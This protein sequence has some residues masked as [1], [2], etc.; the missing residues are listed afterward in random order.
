MAQAR[1][2]EQVVQQLEQGL[3][4]QQAVITALQAGQTQAQA[5][6]QQAQNEL[7]QAQADVVAARQEAAQAQAV[8]QAVQQQAAA[9]PQGPGGQ[10]GGGGRTRIKIMTFANAADE[11]W[12]VWKFHF[13]KARILNGYTDI[14][15][16]LALSAAMKGR[17]AA[18]VMDIEVQRQFEDINALLQHYDRRFLPAS[19]SQMARVSFDQAVQKQGETILDYHSKIRQLWNRAYPN[20]ADEVLLIRKFSLGLRKKE[21]REQVI[22]QNPQTYGA[23]LEAAQNEASVMRVV[24]VTETGAAVEPMEIG[25]VGAIRRAKAASM[26]KKNTGTKQKQISALRTR[27]ATQKTEA[28]GSKGNCHFCS[29]PGHYRSNCFLFQKAKKLMA[30]G[31]GGSAGQNQRSPPWKKNPRNFQRRTGQF[32]SASISMMETLMEEPEAEGIPEDAF[33]SALE[34]LE[35][36]V[37]EEDEDPD[38]VQEDDEAEDADECFQ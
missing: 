16:K 9:A 15:A 32:S 13:D 23:A 21:V 7:Q 37:D 5:S 3:G 6:L 8:A 27:G 19:A 29:K 24:S 2:L 26:Q 10:G 31:R 18:A 30:G 11:D 33:E 22:R 25:M 34:Q 28:P 35:E 36:L 12:L 20:N 38:D 4:Q 17:A 1:S 14:E